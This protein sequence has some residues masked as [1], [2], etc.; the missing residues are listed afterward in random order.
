MAYDKELIAGKLR[1]WEKY[2]SKFRLPE[3]ESIS[4]I[5]LYMEQTV[6]LLRQYIDYLPPGKETLLP[7][8]YSIPYNNLHAQAEPEPFNAA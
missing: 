4:D 1:R 2:L 8:A 3:W 7:G 6:V 5:G